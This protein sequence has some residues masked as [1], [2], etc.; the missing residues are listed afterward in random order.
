VNALSFLALAAL[1]AGMVI[2]LSQ[3]VWPVA[4]LCLAL[5]LA[6]LAEAGVVPA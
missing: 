3:K 5:A 2:A 1:L 6:L 4:L